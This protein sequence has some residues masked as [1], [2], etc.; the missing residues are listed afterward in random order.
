[1]MFVFFTAYLICGTLIGF[2]AGL[3]GIGGGIIGIPA[4]FVLFQ[5]QG[6]SQSVSMHMAIGT[7]F[8]TIIVTSIV[9]IYSHHRKR[10]ILFSVFKKMFLGIIFGGILCIMISTHVHGVYLQRLFGIFLL[11][12]SVL[13]WLNIKR[14]S[15][16]YYVLPQTKN[17]F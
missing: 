1:M 7:F 3:F 10:M 5:I 2:F 14:K 4:L 9:A 12:I 16:T 15:N 17:I 8:A 11:C 13:M 6:M